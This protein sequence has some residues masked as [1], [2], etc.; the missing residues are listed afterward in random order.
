MKTLYNA[1]HAHWHSAA[2]PNWAIRISG[3]A[4]SATFRPSSPSFGSQPDRLALL[5]TFKHKILVTPYSDFLDINIRYQIDLGH[6]HG[7]V[8]GLEGDGSLQASRAAYPSV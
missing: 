4:V 8:P 1:I 2:V 6:W 5:A 7:D 3:G